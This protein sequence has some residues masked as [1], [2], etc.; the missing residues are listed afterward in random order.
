VGVV[1][2]QECLDLCYTEDSRASV[3]LNLVLCGRGQ[4]VEVQGTAEGQPF[5]RQQLDKLVDLATGG[6]RQ[7]FELQREALGDEG[8]GG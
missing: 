5:S 8:I 6:I 4:I 7:L 2:G 3:D 1:A